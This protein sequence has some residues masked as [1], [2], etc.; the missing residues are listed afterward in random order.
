VKNVYK[1]PVNLSPL[2]GFQDKIDLGLERW[3]VSKSR[4]LFPLYGF[5]EV[6]PPSLERT[7]I[8]DVYNRREA[9]RPANNIYFQLSNGNKPEEVM[10]ARTVVMSVARM[11]ASEI[12][13]SRLEKVLPKKVFYVNRCWRNENSKELSETTLREFTQLGCESVGFP[14]PY[15]TAEAIELANEFLYGLGIPKGIVQTRINSVKIFD[16]LCEKEGLNLGNKDEIRGPIDKIS[17]YRCLKNSE[18]MKAY[19]IRLIK[20]LDRLPVSQKFRNNMQSLTYLTGDKEVIE[21]AREELPKDVEDGIN[22]LNKLS[23]LLSELG[24]DYKI[25]FACVRGALPEYTGIVFQTDVTSNETVAELIG[26]GEYN[27]LISDLLFT[28]KS[29][30]AVGWASGVERV[31]YAFKNLVKQSLVTLNTREQTTIYLNDKPDIV[32]FSNN[33]MK[34]LRK[35]KRLRKEGIRTYAFFGDVKNARNYASRIDT[36]LLVLPEDISPTDR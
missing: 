6:Q 36:D 2:P 34:T 31:E 22:E 1:S 10:L 19:E 30:P 14:S 23:M 35:A 3:I 33:P 15:A 7:E 4:N 13:R 21:Q 24:I 12:Q 16:R 20:A 5:E 29:I 32:L 28:S 27:R 9:E 17:K 26:G 8:F 11:I 18:E 25:D